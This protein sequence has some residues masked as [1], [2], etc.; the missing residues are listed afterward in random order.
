MVRARCY[1]DG[2]KGEEEKCLSRVRDKY[3]DAGTD[4]A[5][6][7]M[8]RDAKDS[9]KNSQRVADALQLSDFFVDNNVDRK[10]LSYAMEAFP[11]Y[12]VKSNHGDW[13]VY[14]AQ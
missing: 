11:K 12:L 8:C 13:N 4:S 10:L 7:F 14:L 5:K 6:K 9:L 3:S 2:G 1:Q